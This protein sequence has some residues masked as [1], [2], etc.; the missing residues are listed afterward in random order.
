MARSQ[1]WGREPLAAALRRRVRSGASEA[2]RTSFAADSGDESI[3]S[4]PSSSGDA[5]ETLRQPAVVP[6]VGA[7]YSGT[8][9][10]P[11]SAHRFKH[12][13][14]DLLIFSFSDQMW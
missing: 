10:S 7:G 14:I 1:E 8:M 6:R 4:E 11:C 12:L 9:T 3:A 5:P 13:A 2:A